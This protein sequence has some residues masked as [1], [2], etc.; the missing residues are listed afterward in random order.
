[1]H[2]YYLFYKIIFCA[3][4]FFKFSFNFFSLFFEFLLSFIWTLVISLSS[5]KVHFPSLF[6]SWI[7]H[8]YFHFQNIVPCLVWN[9]WLLPWWVAKK[10]KQLY[11]I[12]KPT[13]TYIYKMKSIFKHL[14]NKIQVVIWSFVI[15]CI[16]KCKYG[17]SYKKKTKTHLKVYW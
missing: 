7:Y 13:F 17:K 15:K 3:C 5:Y 6:H 8:M 9:Y 2:F 11:D 12:L 4:N 1:M 10:A 16:G 14:Q